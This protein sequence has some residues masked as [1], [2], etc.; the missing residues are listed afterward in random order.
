MPKYMSKFMA[1]FV[2]GYL[3][4][5]QCSKQTNKKRDIKEQNKIV[6]DLKT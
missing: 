5:V 6:F 4:L 1:K 3:Y 2:A